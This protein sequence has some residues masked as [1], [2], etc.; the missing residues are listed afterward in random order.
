VSKG[1]TPIVQSWEAEQNSIIEYKKHWINTSEEEQE[2]EE[3]EEEALKAIIGLVPSCKYMPFP[4][5]SK[6]LTTDCP[7]PI[8]HPTFSL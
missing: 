8:S 1:K 7:T 2:P 3:Q 4:L 5:L 6:L